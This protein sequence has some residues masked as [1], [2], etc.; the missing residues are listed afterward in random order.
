VTVH[1]QHAGQTQSSPEAARPQARA[2]PA[3]TGAAWLKDFFPGYF[4]LVMGTGIMA[5]AAQLLHY[6]LFAWPLFVIALVAYA[7]LWAILL[8]RLARFPRAVLADF[9]SH[10]RG[11]AFLTIV[12][13]NGVLGS[14]FDEFNVLTGL[15]PVLFWFSLG[16]WCVLVYGFLSAVTVG[17]TKPDL[18]HGLNGAWLLLVVATES[19]A[20]LSGLLALRRGTP[21]PLVFTSLAFYLLG[22]M[23]YVLLT[24]LIFFRWIFRPMHPAEMGASWWIN[25]GA[26]AIATLAGAQ[27]M[28]LPGVSGNLAP[29]VG[30]VAPFTVL[31]WATSTFWIPL[32]VILFIWKELQRGP[33]G[34]DP[35][36]WSAVFP[37]GMYVAAT[38]NYATVAGLAFLEPVPQLL[39]WIA[40]LTWALTFIGM[41]VHLLRARGA[42]VNRSDD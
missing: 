11:P 39:F 27:L 10:E 23:L 24:A 25:M 17:I 9:T 21:P 42:P 22:S 14:Q 16:L 13:A 30:F 37:L 35:G 33:H 31:L 15:L 20:V 1:P 2:H 4:A 32:L 5:V 28:A 7:V 40:L 18:E 19:L 36:L 41:W 6:E 8:A 3:V 26:V 29:L 34:Y 38:H 12:A